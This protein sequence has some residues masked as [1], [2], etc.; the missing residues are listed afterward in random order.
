ME[1]ELDSIDDMLVGPLDFVRP[2]QPHELFE[3]A[4][5]DAAGN[6]TLRRQHRSAETEKFPDDLED[7]RLGTEDATNLDLQGP[8]Q[9][10]DDLGIEG[11]GDGDGHPPGVPADGYDHVL[12]GEEAGDDGGHQGHIELER[13]D[14]DI[15]HA[16]G[17]GDALGDEFLAEDFAAGTGDLE[18]EGGDNLGRGDQP[19]SG[20]LFSGPL[21]ETSGPH[22]SKR[23]RR[24]Y[25]LEVNCRLTGGQLQCDWTYSERM[26]RRDTVAGLAQGFIE[27]L[28]M[29]I[30]HCQSPE[31]GGYT[32][33]DFPTMRLNQQ[34]LDEL[35]ITLSEPGTR[36]EP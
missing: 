23:G 7:F 29:L 13:V 35:M 8:L 11:I 33:S 18:I 2:F 28:R 25:L 1:E 17:D 9:V 21:R 4:K 22:R 19:R 16:D 24:C 34:E 3:V 5:I 10:V 14:L 12:E 27:A 31:A 26:H 36:D 32:P 15:V 30:R 20:P 6:F